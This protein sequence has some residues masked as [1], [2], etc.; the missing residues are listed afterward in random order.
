MAVFDAVV[1]NADR[2]GGHLLPLPDRPRLRRRPRRLLLRRGQAAHGAVAVAGQAAGPRG[3]GG[4]RQA[5]A[6][7]GVR[8]RSAAGCATCS[9][10]PRSRPPGSGCAGCSTPA[11]IRP[12]RRT[13]LPSPGH[14]SKPVLYA[15]PHVHGDR[16]DRA[17]AHPDGCAGRVHRSALGGPRG[18]LARASGRD[19]RPDLKAGGTWLAVDPAARR[20]AALLNGHGRAAP[21]DDASLPRRPAAAAAPRATLPER[22]PDP[23]RP[24]PSACSP[25]WRRVRLCSWD[26]ERLAVSELPDGHQHDRQHR[27]GPGERAR[28]RLP[29]GFARA[30]DRL[31]GAHHR[32]ALRRPRAR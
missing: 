10:W 22:R 21:E 15:L 13:G 8:A 17:A 4:A 19:R 1:N 16:E 5:G 14:P 28:R 7:P 31:A 20:A 27:A 25:T 26:G 12:P 9:R 29:A 30:T 32:S 24:L 3:G 18:A 2:K 23:L 6:R 11:C